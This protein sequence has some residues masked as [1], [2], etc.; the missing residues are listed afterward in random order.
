MRSLCRTGAEATTGCS[1]PEERGEVVSTS[2]VITI[3][4]FLIMAHLSVAVVVLSLLPG[5]VVEE[6]PG[7]HCTT[8]FYIKNRLT[9]HSLGKPLDSLVR[10]VLQNDES[11]VSIEVPENVQVICFHLKPPPCLEGRRGEEGRNERGGEMR[12]FQTSYFFPKVVTLA[13]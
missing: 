7:R 4:R 10:R 2:R 3:F 6:G 1:N 12:S 13:L 5:V 9:W 8:L 11:E